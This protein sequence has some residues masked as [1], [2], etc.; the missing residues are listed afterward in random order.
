MSNLKSDLILGLETSCDETAAA[1]VV[2][3]S[4]VLSNIIAS[5]IKVHMPYGGVVPEIASRHHLEQVNLVIDLALKEAKVTLADLGGV[6]VT[7]G[8]GLVG[9]L[10]VGVSAAKGLAYGASLPFL[11]VN[12]LE[13]HI[14]A[15]LLGNCS[16][17]ADRSGSPEKKKM[18]LI[19]SGGHTMLILWH[20]DK[21]EDRYKVLGFSRD[22][23]CGEALDKV[24]RVLGLDYPGGPA[25]ER[26]A[27]EGDAKAYKFPATSFPDSLDFSFSG[28][29]TA[30]VNLLHNI[31]QSGKELN[32]A[33]FAASYQSA[34]VRVLTDKVKTALLHNATTD[35]VVV[36]GVAANGLLRE[37]MQEIAVESDVKLHIPPSEFCTDN[38]AMVAVLGYRRLRRGERSQLCLNAYPSLKLV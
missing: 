28:I 37:K 38:A 2:A 32:K 21:S 36:G 17:E 29:K 13:S 20:L 5:Q 6:A 35:L 7:C 18:V 12:H 8:P 14:M 26:L 33:D 19:I 27:R 22:D 11:G 25:I 10:L 24:A 1:V 34:I 23:A 15:A 4:H 31:R 3:G 30:A 16:D 9:S